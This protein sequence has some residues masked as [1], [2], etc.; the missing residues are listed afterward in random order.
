[1]IDLSKLDK[2]SQLTVRSG[3]AFEEDDHDHGNTEHEEHAEHDDDHDHEHEELTNTKNRQNM[4]MTTIMSTKNTQTMR[5]N[6]THII[7]L[8][9]KTQ[10]SWLMQFATN[11]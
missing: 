5:V 9:P 3:G 4:M 10:K 2:L 11:L 8:I 7:G 1:M 6:L